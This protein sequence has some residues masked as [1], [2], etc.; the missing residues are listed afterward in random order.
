MASH[1]QMSRQRTTATAATRARV[2]TT[3]PSPIGELLLLSNGTALTGL[4]MPDNR[5]SPLGQLGL[6]EDARP[7]AEVIGQLDAYFAHRLRT[8]DL[9]LAPSGTPFQRRVWQALGQIPYGQTKSYGQ[10]ALAL[11]HPGAGRA[12]GFASARNPLSLIVPCHRVVG[13]SGQLTGYASGL[14]R[15]RWLLAHEAAGYQDR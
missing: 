7:F 9:A 11:G 8:F 10:I 12:V 4:Y 14:E 5:F 6:H 1:R 15:K 3:L 13:S 2:Y